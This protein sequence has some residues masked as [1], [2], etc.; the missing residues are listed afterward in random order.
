MKV[1]SWEARL[2]D[3]IL[4][5]GAVVVGAAACSIE[6]STPCCNLSPDPCC[7]HDHCGGPITVDCLGARSCEAQ[8]GTFGGVY[9]PSPG[10]MATTCN[11][12]IDAGGGDSATE[13]STTDAPAF[14]AGSFFQCCN[15]NSDPCCPY[16]YCEASLTPECSD[17]LV[18]TS[19]GGTWSL[20][21]PVPDASHCVLAQDGLFAADAGSD[22][23]AGESGDAGD[24]GVE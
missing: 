4:A 5:G 3:L 17:K 15:A 11:F 24:A 7:A 20:Y 23:E 6:A 13:D 10:V 2:R 22:A 18:C 14:D 9:Y 16:M 1:V 19:E 8:G 12:T 21:E